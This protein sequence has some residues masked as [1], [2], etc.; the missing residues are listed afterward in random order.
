MAA[1]IAM[2]ETHQLLSTRRLTLSRLRSG[3]ATMESVSAAVVGHV[4][5]KPGAIS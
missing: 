3:M 2:V 1:S 4:V 5:R